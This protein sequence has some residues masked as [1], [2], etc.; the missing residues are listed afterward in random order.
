MSNFITLVGMISE[1]PVEDGTIPQLSI[2]V[3]GELKTLLS[4]LHTHWRVLEDEIV[5]RRNIVK[6][7]IKTTAV[8]MG[9]VLN[10][11][12]VARA[13]ITGLVNTYEQL[14]SKYSQMMCGYDLEMKYCDDSAFQLRMRMLVSNAKL[15]GMLEQLAATLIILIR[16]EVDEEQGHGE[17]VNHGINIMTAA[18]NSLTDTSKRAL[19]C[20]AMTTTEIDTRLGSNGVD[21]DHVFTRTLAGIQLLA[22]SIDGRIGSLNG[23]LCDRV[24]PQDHIA[25]ARTKLYRMDMLVHHIHQLD[26]AVSGILALTLELTIGRR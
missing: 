1:I 25:G 8:T 26:S 17:V 15:N 20:I 13:G 6:S 24:I 7:N 12:T 10:P 22:T 3:A 5:N 11:P 18:A 23:E 9:Y 4:V 19:G 16:G 14:Q 21:G 2:E